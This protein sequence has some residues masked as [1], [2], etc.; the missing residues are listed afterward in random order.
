MTKKRK[1]ERSAHPDER[2]ALLKSLRRHGQVVEA[3]DSDAG[4]GPGQTHVYVKKPGEEGGQ[5]IERRKS[6]FKR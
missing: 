4:L 6:F 2:A 1:V 5:L 3:E